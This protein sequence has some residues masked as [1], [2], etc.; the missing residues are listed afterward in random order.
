MIIQY[1]FT[2][3]STPIISIMIRHFLRNPPSMPMPLVIIAQ[4]QYY[5]FIHAKLY[6][7]KNARNR[8]ALNHVD[9]HPVE[10]LF[11]FVRSFISQVCD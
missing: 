9:L 5:Y 6:S 8:Q 2:L 7:E 1:I 4:N 11:E 10:I 3:V